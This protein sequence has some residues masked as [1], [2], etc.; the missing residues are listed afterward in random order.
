MK[1]MFKD[2]TSKQCRK[3][4]EIKPRTEFP[5]NGGK[6]I[7]YCRD[8]YKATGLSHNLSKFGL[9]PD[10]YIEMFENQDGVCYICKQPELSANKKRLCVDHD[11]S[12]CGKGKACNKCV[13]KLLCFQCNIALGAVKDNI[14]VLKNMI[15]YLEK[16]S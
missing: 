15:A 14:T 2:E 8:C 5:K 3:C 11:H 9:T 12:C 16:H 6:K 4:E 13:R 7:S 10:D 1:P